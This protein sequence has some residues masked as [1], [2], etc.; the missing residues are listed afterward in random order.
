MD[1]GKEGGRDE[2]S[3]QRE[4]GM[5]R[6]DTGREEGGMSRVDKGREEGASLP[7]SGL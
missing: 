7:G 1:K 5:S 6:V 3:G 2:Q 4:G